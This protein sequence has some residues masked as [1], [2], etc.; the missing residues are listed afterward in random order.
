MDKPFALLIEDDRD[1]AALFRHVLDMAGYESESILDG[2]EAMDR[3]PSLNPDIV[4]LDLQLPNIS[5]VEILK[6][7]RTDEKMKNIPVV[8][9]TA[10]AYYANS[11]PVEPDLFLLKPVDIHDLISLIQRL[12]ATKDTT[13]DSPYDEV[14]HLHTVS[15]F[16]MR[17]VFVLERVRRMELENFGV[18]FADIHPYNELQ[19]KLNEEVLNALLHKMADRFKGILRPTETMAWSED[20]HF[21]TLFEEFPSEE[22]PSVIADRVGKGLNEFLKHHELGDGLRAQVGVIMCDDGYDSVQEILDDVNFAR[23]LVRKE[24]DSGY[25]LYKR[26]ELQKLRDSQEV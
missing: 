17:L 23:E 10:Y 8:V 18:L 12:R 21:L 16:S 11:L 4:L 3:L 15:F 7:M 13:R 5:G 26:A 14:T 2:K 25:W 24:P 22:I 1:V 19:H 20:G 6:R 9:I